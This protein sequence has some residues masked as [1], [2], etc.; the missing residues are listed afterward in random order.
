VKRKAIW[1]ACVAEINENHAVKED[2]DKQ[3]L[4]ASKTMG[5]STQTY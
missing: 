4:E 5:Q 3:M 1:D 2:F